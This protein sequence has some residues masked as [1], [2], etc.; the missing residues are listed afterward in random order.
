MNLN[1]I[2]YKQIKEGLDKICKMQY[3]VEN[4]NIVYIL[5][6]VTENSSFT[7]KELLSSKLSK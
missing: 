1:K 7:F 2:T 4:I 6:K 3:T 5:S